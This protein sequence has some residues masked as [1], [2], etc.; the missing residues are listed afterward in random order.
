MQINVVFAVCY[1]A[2]GWMQPLSLHSNQS[3]RAFQHCSVLQINSGKCQK[4]NTFFSGMKTNFDEDAFPQDTCKI[5]RG[6]IG[7]VLVAV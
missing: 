7:E 6:V 5:S 4:S 2:H 1:E 3:C